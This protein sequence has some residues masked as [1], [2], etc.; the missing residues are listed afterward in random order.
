MTPV[1]TSQATPHPGVWMGAGYGAYFAAV[2]CFFPYIALYY[3]H[4]G[5]SGPAIGLLTAIP[6]LAT[7]LLAP[8][9]GLVA[10]RYGLHRRVL[11]GA[12]ILSGVAALGLRAATGFAPLLIAV[13]CFALVAAPVLP[14][15]DSFGITI[16]QRYGLAYGKLRLWGSAGYVVAAS[17]VGWLMGGTV[18]DGFLAAYALALLLAVGATAG[19]PALHGQQVRRTWSGTAGLVRRP[20]MVILLVTGFLV[21]VGTS[22]LNT[23]LGIY[24]AALGGGAGLIGAANALAAVSE[25]PILLG[26][27]TLSRGLGSRRLLIL[28]VVVYIGRLVAVSVIPGPGWVFPVQLFHG[29][30]FGANLMASVTLVNQIVGT[31]RA[32]TGQGLLASA[33][34][35][36]T[37]TGS[38]AGGELLDR[39]GVVAVFRLAAV[40]MLLGLGVFLAGRR[41]MAAAEQQAT[42]GAQPS[43]P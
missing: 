35:L 30:S 11:R 41:W 5:L 29:L 27:A 42:R 25:I 17:A 37:I 8:V 36:G 24:L 13:V 40:V 39:I 23:F 18:S 10:D 15:L 7:A 4:L 33:L 14:L 12:L 2:G 32:A 34:A 22:A 16:S 3:R 21:S 20:A 28:A 38:V 6:P 1:S 9:W 19:L 43:T 26:G 31:E